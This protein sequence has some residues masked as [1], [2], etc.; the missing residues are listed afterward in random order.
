[1]VK[2]QSTCICKNMT[3]Q[4]QLTATETQH[5]I[6][7]KTYQ[8]WS[9]ILQ[10]YRTLHFVACLHNC[11]SLIASYIYSLGSKMWQFCI[12][13]SRL[14]HTSSQ[15]LSTPPPPLPTSLITPVCFIHV[16]VYCIS[17]WILHFR[18]CSYYLNFLKP[19]YLTTANSTERQIT[20]DINWKGR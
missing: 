7:D 12:L 18:I 9:M 20:E 11:H 6:T 10:T 15:P 5:Q 16:H 2:I 19:I 1:M 8:W 17:D 14:C 3:F 4:A 13:W